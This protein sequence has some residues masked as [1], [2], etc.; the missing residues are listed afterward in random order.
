MKLILVRIN[1]F[2]LTLLL[3]FLFVE[4][5]E[6]LHNVHNTF[7]V[8]P[9]HKKIP[10]S[11]LSPYQR[12]QASKLNIK[13]GVSEKLIA[14][15]TNKE[16]YVLHYR[17]LQQVIGLGLKINKTHSK[18]YIHIFMFWLNIQNVVSLFFGPKLKQC[19]EKRLKV[20]DDTI[21]EP[22]YLVTLFF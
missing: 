14:D 10:K 3:N 4:Y 15:L 8:C 5:P 9:S 1:F 17:N 2:K 19:S 7:P 11:L 6:I 16:N 22:K 20:S 18:V 12:E 21:R 13:P